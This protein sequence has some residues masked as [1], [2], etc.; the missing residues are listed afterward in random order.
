MYTYVDIFF[1]YVE[2]FTVSKIKA[3]GI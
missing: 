1:M 3:N 2:F